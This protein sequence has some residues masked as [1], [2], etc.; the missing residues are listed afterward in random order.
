MS[1]KQS[2]SRYLSMV[3]AAATTGLL[4]A[5]GPV[6]A[7]GP[8]SRTVTVRY[9]D[10]DLASDA[11]VRTLYARLRAAAQQVCGPRASRD[12]Y[13]QQLW[14]ACR[15]DTLARAVGQLGNAKLAVLHE[16]RSSRHS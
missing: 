4:L 8:E 13:M 15:D 16:R 2:S 5:A 9:A 7:A 12:L 1:T 6:M 10:L 11:G 3:F 14:R